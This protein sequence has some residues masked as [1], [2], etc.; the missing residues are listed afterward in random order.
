VSQSSTPSE[1]PLK[2]V[3]VLVADDHLRVRETL[4]R[5]LCR[6]FQVVGGAEDGAS[7]LR[8]VAELSPDVIVV[9]VS[10]PDM[11]GFS[12]LQ[13]LR[14]NGSD[15]KVILVS[16]FHQPSFVDI[17]VKRGASG[18]VS[19]YAAYDELIPA[20]RAALDG[21]IYSSTSMKNN[22]GESPRL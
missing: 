12:V 7:L 15:V 20:V 8:A 1:Q 9:D 19:K 13:Q 6:E 3:R 16:A 10:M 2:H 21:K 11:D 17:A 5:I 14:S 4:E 22:P 18:F